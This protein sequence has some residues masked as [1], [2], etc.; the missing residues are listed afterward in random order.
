[1][2]CECNRRHAGTK[3]DLENKIEDQLNLDVPPVEIWVEDPN[4]DVWDWY[5]IE[6][7]LT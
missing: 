6:L 5:R 3:Q 7:G 4:W 2:W 1:M